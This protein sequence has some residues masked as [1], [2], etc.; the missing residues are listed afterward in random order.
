MVMVKVNGPIV[1][2]EGK[3]GG[4]VYRVD[5]CG[6]HIQSYPRI[7][8]RHKVSPQQKGFRKS[9]VAWSRHKWTQSEINRWWVW[10]KGN[11]TKNKKGETTYFH[12]FTGF[13]HVNIKR[14]IDGQDIT[15][16]PP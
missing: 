16:N 5:Q 13:L 14:T 12:P 10:C 11:P 3:M 7:I 8:D 2:I 9:V 15:F 1:E 4:N 6:Q